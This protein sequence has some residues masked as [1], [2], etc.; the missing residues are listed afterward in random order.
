MT[1]TTAIGGNVC[2]RDGE[3]TDFPWRECIASLLPVCST[4]YVC[5]GGSTD[6]TLD[7]IQEWMTREPKLRLIHYPWP[8]PKGRTH[9]WVEWLNYARDHIHEPW[10][11]QLDAD[12]VLYE[13]SYDWIRHYVAT[14]PPPAA[15]WCQR[16]NFWRDPWHLV[17]SGHMCG[18]RVAR[19]ASTALWMPT[20]YPHPDGELLCQLAGKY[21]VAPIKIGHYGALRSRAGM[22]L[23]QRRYQEWTIGSLD[24]R[25][26]IAEQSANWC[27]SVAEQCGWADKVASYRGDHPAVIKQWL[28]DRGFKRV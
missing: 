8:S 4:V 6:G 28:R 24:P 19:L 16:L 3:S 23:K 18:D 1:S 11:L 10:H 2:I 15:V 12:E 13:D 17:P 7:A 5:D 26:A 14:T 21:P 27:D 9:F 20:D 25:I 22:A